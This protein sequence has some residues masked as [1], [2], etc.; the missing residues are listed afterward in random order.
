GTAVLLIT[1]NLGVIANM[2]ERVGVMYQGRVVEEA[3]VRQIFEQPSHPFTQQL[4]A[5][6]DIKNSRA[7]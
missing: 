6:L 1:H 5:S 7:S 2:A 4:I 3:P